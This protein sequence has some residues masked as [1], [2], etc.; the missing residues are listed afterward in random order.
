MGSDDGDANLHCCASC[1]CGRRGI[2]I[3]LGVLSLT[4]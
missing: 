2:E 3:G 1:D 4:P